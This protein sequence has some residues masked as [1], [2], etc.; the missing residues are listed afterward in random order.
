MQK[1]H[2]RVRVGSAV[3]VFL[4]YDLVGSVRQ[5]RHSGRGETGGSAYGDL[6]LLPRLP[7]TAVA[8][9]NTSLTVLR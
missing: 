1:T 8:V 9:V 2:A 5:R 3:A 7:T 6:S 4:R